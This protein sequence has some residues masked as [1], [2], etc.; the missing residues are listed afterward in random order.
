[1]K[2]IIRS[3]MALTAAVLSVL[4]L[5]AV[6]SAEEIEQTA[7]Q[8]GWVLKGDRCIYCY[9]DGSHAVGTVEIDGV[10]YVFAPNGMQQVGWQDADGKRLYYD[11]ETG[12]PVFGWVH[13][14]GED[15]YISEETGKQ[16]ALADTEDGKILPDAYGVIQKDAWLTDG[17]VWYHADADGL[18][19]AGETVVDGVL[20]LFDENSAL[21]TGF[22]TDSAGVLRYY[23]PA[24]DAADIPLVP[25]GW[26]ELDG[27][28]YYLD[29]DGAVQTGL[30]T[31]QGDIF[32]FD[33]EGRLL[34]GWQELGGC[35]YYFGEDAKA[36]RGLQDIDG[37]TYYF[38]GSAVMQ[39]GSIVLG[40][41]YYFDTDGKRIDGFRET[42]AGT[43]YRD[44]TDGEIVTGWQTIGEAEYYFDADGIMA[45]GM[46]TLDGKNY[47]FAE[48]GVYTPV[49]ICLDAG[50]YAL[51]NH[52]PVNPAYWESNFTW[53]MHLYLKE[54]LESYNI[55]VITTREDK[56]TDLGLETRGRMSAG[57]D[58]FLSIHSN[59][60]APAYYDG[61]L[62]CVTITGVCDELGLAMAN[63][64]ADVMQTNQRGSIWKR[65]GDKFPDLDYYGVLRGATYVGTP[66]ILL[67]HSYHTNLRATQWLLVDANVRKLAV[68]EARFL[69]EHFNMIPEASK[70]EGVS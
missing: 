54:E 24:F 63:L 51:Y 10:P 28:T 38:D 65:H 8:V 22:Q 61:P 7:P 67:E 43:I 62:A 6:S 52:S 42:E 36:L 57:C 13:W 31:L 4:C 5:T 69:A 20:C 70:K 23:D 27:D 58:L 53:Q 2:Q 56:D 16:T 37:D 33:A 34:H 21:K 17:T 3:G 30:L 15:Y 41:A 68:A 59:A 40:T 25:Q 18:L 11:P 29:E 12:K 32:G 48:D 19:D 39:T 35:R 55:E 1:M 26:T 60:G 64:V 46:Q 44:P 9:E 45:T 66:A 50:H 49:K 14:R 47:R